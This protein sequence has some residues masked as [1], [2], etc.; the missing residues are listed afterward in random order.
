MHVRY[1]VHFSYL[2]FRTLFLPFSLIVSV[3]A[4]V[5]PNLTV[6]GRKTGLKEDLK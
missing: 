1:K 5:L 2:A 4:N 6:A 3:L